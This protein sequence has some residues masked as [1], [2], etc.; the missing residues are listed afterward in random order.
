MDASHP[1]AQLLGTAS[2]FKLET[3]F[4]DA[5]LDPTAALDER[6]LSAPWR[7]HTLRWLAQ[8]APA[9]ALAVHNAACLLDLEC[10]IVDGSFSR[11]LQATLLSHVK[12]ALDL[13]SWEGVACPQLLPG[14]IG[15]DAR[16]IGGALLPL[17]A[18]FAPDR[19]LFLK[20]SAG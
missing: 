14:T 8:A 5:G 11:P 3:L 18:H 15:S 12:D 4:I 19:E 10:A 1:P 7:Q 9:V 2:L 20:L 17:Y 6:S 13:H 16:A